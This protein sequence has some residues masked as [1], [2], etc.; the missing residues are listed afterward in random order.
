MDLT[1]HLG[2]VPQQRSEI[3]DSPP[4]AESTPQSSR[5]VDFSGGA[6]GRAA[7]GINSTAVR[8]RTSAEVYH[9]MIIVKYNYNV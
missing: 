7:F 8:V 9:F 2:P 3:E 4:L 6:Y 5:S 1:P